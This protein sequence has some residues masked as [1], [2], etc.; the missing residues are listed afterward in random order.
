MTA[1]TRGRPSPIIMPM[2]IESQSRVEL[3]PG[4]ASRRA[5]ALHSAGI[6]TVA[7]LLFYKPFRYEDRTNF[8]VIGDLRAGPDVVVRAEILAA[9]AFRTPR[10]GV[11]IFEMRVGDPT[12]SLAVK[13][14]NQ[15]YLEKTLRK[16]KRVIL[17]G[18]PQLDG[19]SLGLSLINPDWELVEAGDEAVHSGR[20]TPVYRRIG[21][22]QSKALRTILHG[23]LNPESGLELEET[24]PEDVLRRHRFPS[25]LE[26]VRSIHFPEFPP[27]RDRN[28][29]LAELAAGR[30]P[31]HRRMVFEELLFFQM[32]LGAA[33]AR[34]E[35]VPKQRSIRVTKKAR[36]TVKSILPF[37]PTRA[38]KRALKEIVADL[39]GPKVMNRLLQGDVGSGKTIVALQAMVVVMES[40]G[41]CALMAPTEILA[42]QHFESIQGPLS[43][44]PFQIGFLSG[45]VKGKE[46]KDVLAR[47]GS[48]QVQLVVGTHAMF[49]RGVEFKK[50]EFVVIDEQHRFGVLQRSRLIEKGERPDTLVMTATPIPRSLALTLYGDLDFSVLDEMPPGRRPVRTLIKSERQRGQVY[51]GLKRQLD[52]GRQAF[53]VYPLVEESEKL[54]LKAAT[55]MAERLQKS[56]LADYRVG[57][58]HGRLKA[59]VKE[60]LMRRFKN[61]EIDVLVAT[62]VVEVGIDV[63]NASLMI[64]EHADRFGLSQLH[65]LRGRVGRG[66]HD[67]YCILMFDESLSDTARQRLQVMRETNDGFKIS[68]KDLELRGPGEFGGTRQW[69]VPN[70]RFANI[71]RDRDWLELARREAA[72][73]LQELFTGRSAEEAVALLK[74]R[75]DRGFGFF[76]VG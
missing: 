16:G 52:L 18:A 28:D 59:D 58:L 53:V 44:T 50:L 62:T 22:L 60:D 7:D 76:E 17:F 74:E 35:M 21:P 49:Q 2:R 24:L 69:G 61:R 66:A 14:F 40:G 54:D 36:E 45:K 5:E 23:L 19:Y 57:L 67:S 4:I 32:G 31:F 26:A 64:I 11:Q 10:R 51:Q 8:Q 65:Q 30:T 9:G 25:R 48:G 43:K 73:Q 27:D 29:F 71:V 63:P 1:F 38:Q 46:R 72:G 12:G 47:V 6:L 75:W 70:F 33:K 41:Q 13:F 39:A 37:H 42:E 68:E 55:E 15:P 56:D 34:R 20:V 3:I